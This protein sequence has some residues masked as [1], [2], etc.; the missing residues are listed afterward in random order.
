MRQTFMLFALLAGGTVSAREPVT[1][2]YDHQVTLVEHEVV[3][4]AEAM[5]ADRRP[6]VSPMIGPATTSIAEW[7]AMPRT[8]VLP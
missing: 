8:E 1:E 7:P 4:L 3:S 6:P 5:P 2:M